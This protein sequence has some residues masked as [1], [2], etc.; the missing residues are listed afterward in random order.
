MQKLFVSLE[1]KVMQAVNKPEKD[2]QQFISANWN[3]LFPGY[4]FIAEEFHLEGDVHG[5]GKKGRIDILAFHSVEKRFVIFE[6]KKDYNDSVISQV[7]HYRYFIQSKFLGVYVKAKQEHGIALPNEKEMKKDVAIVIIAKTFNNAQIDFA[8]LSTE[9]IKL[10]KYN[11]FENDILLLDYVNNALDCKSETKSTGGTKNTI[12]SE[13]TTWDEVV[14]AFVRQK[15]RAKY[16]AI[17]PDTKENIEKLRLLA[18]KIP[19]KKR[20]TAVLN[21]LTLSEKQ[22]EEG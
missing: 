21:F 4:T 9:T 19:T 8:R 17:A 15:Y 1:N 14:N 22:L 10:V 12:V 7:A 2:L 20:R 13:E 11:W 3:E 5:L 18:S 6:L 16:K